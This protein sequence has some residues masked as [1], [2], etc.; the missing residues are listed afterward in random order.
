MF[1]LVQTLM[2]RRLTPRHVCVVQVPVMHPL[3]CI[4][5]VQ[6]AHA[7]KFRRPAQVL[8][9]RLKIWLIVNVE[10]LRVLLAQENGANQ[11]RTGVVKLFLRSIRFFTKLKL[12]ALATT[13]ES[14]QKQNAFL[15]QKNWVGSTSQ[16]FMHL[17]TE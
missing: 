1:Q 9:D 4:V 15:Q 8:R 5:L 14:L 17:L 7:Q 16:Q 3:V 10:L 12:Q 11:Q 13:T 6:Q 2:Q